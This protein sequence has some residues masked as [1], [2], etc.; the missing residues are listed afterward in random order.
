[1]SI[2][3]FSVYQMTIV[4]YCIKMGHRG[5]RLSHKIGTVSSIDKKVHV[6]VFHFQLNSTQLNKPPRWLTRGKR[7]KELNRIPDS[8]ND[9]QDAF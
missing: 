6:E 4:L 8:L 1:M 5:S 3:Y 2:L 9:S 7:F